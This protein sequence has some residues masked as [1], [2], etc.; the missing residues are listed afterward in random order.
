MCVCVVLDVQ[1]EVDGL[2]EQEKGQSRSVI[3]DCGL[4]HSTCHDYYSLGTTKKGIG[5]T[6]S[7][8]VGCTVTETLS[9]PH[10]FLQAGRVGLRV[11]DL[12]IDPAIFRAKLTL[13]YNPNSNH[14]ACTML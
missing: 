7:A 10:L 1:Q 9:E 4:Q 5:P 13:F 8:K 14:G 11:C 2:I 6:Y 12:Y 3:I